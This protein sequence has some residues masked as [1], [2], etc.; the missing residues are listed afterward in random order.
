MDLKWRFEKYMPETLE[1]VNNSGFGSSDPG[2]VAPKSPTVTPKVR[3]CGIGNQ[4]HSWAFLEVKQDQPALEWTFILYVLRTCY[5]FNRLLYQL[6]GLS[7]SQWLGLMDGEQLGITCKTCFNPFL[8][9]S[10]I[11]DTP[12]NS[13]DLVLSWYNSHIIQKNRTAEYGTIDL[14]V[15]P[16][17][18]VWVQIW[19]NTWTWAVTEATFKWPWHCGFTR[20]INIS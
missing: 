13:W 4:R 17:E 6:M 10:R 14:E 3:W 11:D 19:N 20:H 5:R 8:R 7:T 18:Q 16:D 15:T 12:V 9:L 1:L 2:Q